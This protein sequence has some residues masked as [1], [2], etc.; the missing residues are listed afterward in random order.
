MNNHMRNN[1]SQIMYFSTPNDYVI[2]YLDK[3][4]AKNPVP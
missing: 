4:T 2:T 3:T 1:E